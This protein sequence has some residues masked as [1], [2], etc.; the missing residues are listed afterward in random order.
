MKATEQFLQENWLWIMAMVFLL[1][2]AVFIAWQLWVEFKTMRAEWQK[3]EAVLLKQQRKMAQFEEANS[4]SVID[5][6]SK[7]LS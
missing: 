2:V 7:Q 3:A 5:Y 6:L 1:A 4:N